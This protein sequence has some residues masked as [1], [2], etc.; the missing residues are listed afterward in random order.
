MASQWT[1]EQAVNPFGT[2][3]DCILISN[4]R[5]GYYRYSYTAPSRILS[6]V[7]NDD[8]VANLSAICDLEDDAVAE[9]CNCISIVLY[10]LGDM[11]LLADYLSTIARSIKNI[12]HSLPEFLV[13]LYLD[14]S[15]V[16]VI[17]NNLQSEFHQFNSEQLDFIINASNTEIY[18]Y[19]FVTDI[20]NTVDVSNSVVDGVRNTIDNTSLTDEVGSLIS[21][22]ADSYYQALNVIVDVN[23][24][25]LVS[26]PGASLLPSV[27]GV[28]LLPSVPGVSLLPSGT[29]GESSINEKQ[30]DLRM[31]RSLRFLPLID[32]TV[33][34]VVIRE[35]D[36]VVSNLDCRNIRVFANSDKFMYMVPYNTLV[37]HT[38][39]YA[40]LYH[41][42]SDNHDIGHHYDHT[43]HDLYKDSKHKNF[44]MS[45]YSYW[46]AA[47]K[48]HWLGNFFSD[49]DN[50]WDLLAG[51]LAFNLKLKADVYYTTCQLLYQRLLS[52]DEVTIL[53]E[54]LS[55]SDG[56]VMTRV[57]RARLFQGFDEILL[58]ELFKELISVRIT[59]LSVYVPEEEDS[60]SSDEEDRLQRLTITYQHDDYYWELLAHVHAFHNITTVNDYVVD[61]LLSVMKRDD[62]LKIKDLQC[63]HNRVATYQYINYFYVIDSLFD[64]DFISLDNQRIYYLKQ[65]SKTIN[66]S[67]TKFSSWRSTDVDR[68]SNNPYN[69]RERVYRNT[70]LALADC[71]YH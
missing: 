1:V 61:S 67:Y 21:D 31:I 49:K 25:S 44:Y 28:S 39:N 26:V 38:D 30:I 10:S 42:S 43:K 59:S 9:R 57:T 51:T 3:H 7:H 62:V 4:R 69:T 29:D 23:D 34:C 46:L 18:T 22:G 20:N 45:A 64:I 17:N 50:L 54:P 27:P 13:R 33:N 66:L 71:F 60:D 15:V 8:F 56:T 36:G 65:L 2:S 58:L 40:D 68:L 5:Q 48:Q 47:Y 12:S 32:D 14:S 55:L 70:P 63:L 6:T 52:A 19:I 24:S 41:Y 37:D 16:T 35:A 11:V 53:S